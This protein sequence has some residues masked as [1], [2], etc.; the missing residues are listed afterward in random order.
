MTKVAKIFCDFCQILNNIAF[1]ETLYKILFGD[2]LEAFGL[3]FTT[4]SGH[5][6]CNLWGD[7][8]F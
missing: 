8:Q 7:M 4:S 1:K 2:L 6:D 3:L 5:T